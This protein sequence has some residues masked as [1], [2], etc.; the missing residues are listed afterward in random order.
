MGQA[1]FVIAIVQLIRAVAG[2]AHK[3]EGDKPDH[4]C[5]NNDYKQAEHAL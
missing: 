4:T 5:E 2:F 1:L 3:F